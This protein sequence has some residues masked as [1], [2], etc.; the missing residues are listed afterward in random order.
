MRDEATM[1]GVVADGGLTVR[2]LIAQCFL[3]GA[4]VGLGMRVARK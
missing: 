1:Y 3:R 2:C 4:A